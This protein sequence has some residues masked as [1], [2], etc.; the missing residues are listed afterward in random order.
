MLFHILR[1][2][3]PD[4]RI[5]TIK[6][7]ICQALHQLSFTH[8]SG[9]NK[10]KGCRTSSGCNL[11]TAAFNSTGKSINCFIL[12]DDALMENI[13]GQ[14]GVAAYVSGKRA[15]GAHPLC[16]F[17]TSALRV[18]TQ[19]WRAADICECVHAGFMPLDQ[20]DGDALCAYIEGMDVRGDAL[21]RPFRFIKDHDEEQLERLNAA[22]ENV[23][24]PLIRLQKA[25]KNAETAD[26][27][28]SAVL[29]LLEDVQAFER[30]TDMRTELQSAQLHVEAED[31][32][33]VWNLL[34]ETLD[35][36]HTL[37]EGTAASGALVLSLLESGLAAL[38]LS[39]LPP[40]DGA[41][42]CGEI[43]NVR[44]AQVRMLF[45]LGM[46]D[47]AGGADSGLLS[48]QER[49]EAAGATGAYLGMSQSERAALEQLDMLKTL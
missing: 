24:A 5:N 41:V 18:V 28:I 9:T 47:S 23:T 13:L 20:A 10:D 42:I 27:T 4:Q 48:E 3:Q 38:E 34:M 43:G 31:C 33:Q 17:V 49:E 40:A 1:H 36:L 25:L 2:I 21:K 22:R 26:D 35:Q 11:H 30:L 32:A 19:G 16:R 14:Y 15:A 7:I 8:T 12:T 44:T 6:H 29:G 39:A 46:N 37:L 45:A